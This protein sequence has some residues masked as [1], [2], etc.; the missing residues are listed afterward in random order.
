LP[1]DDRRQGRILPEEM[2]KATPRQW[3]TEYFRRRDYLAS[4]QSTFSCDPACTRPG[5]K[6]Q[7]LQVPV[8]LIDLM[9]AALHR[10]ESVSATFQKHYSL[11]LLSNDR[12]DWI[13]I[14]TLKV[15]KPCPFLENDRCSIYPVRPLPCI[16]FPEYL[17]N[18]GTFE[19]NAAQDHFKDYLCFRS[20]IPLSPDRAKVMTQLKKMWER[21]SLISSFYLFKHGRCHLDFS[22]LI[23]ELLNE[24]V[25]PGEAEAAG[26]VEPRRIIPNQVMEHFF[27]EH[28]AGCQPLAGTREKLGGLDNPEGQAEFLQFLQ[29]DRLLKKLKRYGDDRALVF[30]Y[31]K[32]RLQ[33]KRRSLSPPEYKF[34]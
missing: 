19:A 3:L 15:K 6:N 18:E 31:V 17:V 1:G 30:R 11:G 27:L 14:V 2:V 22:N 34:Y 26:G 20:H 5:C 7:D 28:L 32:G 13:R 21:E 10:G 29:D 12:E 24:A 4:D 9:G 33:A 23:E 16:L 8:S 25:S